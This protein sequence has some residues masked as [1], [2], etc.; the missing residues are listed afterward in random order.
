LKKC[1]DVEIV[2]GPGATPDQARTGTPTTDF[3]TPEG[4]LIEAIIKF[5]CPAREKSQSI[6]VVNQFTLL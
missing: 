1:G 5:T 4:S 6:L 3:R 2:M